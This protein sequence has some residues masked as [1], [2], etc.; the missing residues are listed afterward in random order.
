MKKINEREMSG[1]IDYANDEIKKI[2]LLVSYN[3]NIGRK[4]S[5]K[6]SMAIDTNLLFTLL[7]SKYSAF[8]L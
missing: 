5:G 1:F 7:V 6:K 4:L 3:F 8:K 2:T